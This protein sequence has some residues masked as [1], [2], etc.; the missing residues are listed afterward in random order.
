MRRAI[1]AVFL[2][3]A[4]GCTSDP[5]DGPPGPQPDITSAVPNPTVPDVT[6]QKF[7]DA[8]ASVGPSVVVTP[9][10]ERV[11]SAKDPSGTILE[12]DPAAGTA[13]EPGTTAT[14]HVV[15]SFH[16][17]RVPDVVGLTLTK[18]KSLLAKSHLKANVWRK[19][20]TEAKWVVLKQSVIAGKDVFAGSKV[21][22]VVAFPHVCGYPLNPWCYS[23]TSGGSVIYSPP[24]NLCDYLNCISSFWSSTNGYVIQCADGEFSHSGGVSGSCSTH[25]GN[26][27][28]LYR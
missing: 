17:V 15:L 5:H 2:A 23:V 19:P 22:V 1:L 20:S 3:F 7:T 14:V 8:R 16:P 12:Q 13:Y 24:S 11:P 4:V 28:P 27:R 10:G 26:W 6:G 18:A 25:D 9:A 21:K